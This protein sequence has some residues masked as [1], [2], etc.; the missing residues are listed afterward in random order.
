MIPQDL[1]DELTQLPASA[2]TAMVTVR[3]GNTNDLEIMSARY[4]SGEVIIECDMI[5]ADND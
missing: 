5:E 3:N 4:Q 1:L 2:R